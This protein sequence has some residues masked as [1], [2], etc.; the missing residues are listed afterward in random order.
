MDL[1]T[2][3]G[4]VMVSRG[5]RFAEGQTLAIGSW[6]LTFCNVGSSL[7]SGQVL[8]PCVDLQNKTFTGCIVKGQSP[9]N[10]LEG[11]EDL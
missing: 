9:W 11:L 3:A 4:T 6:L 8:F 10:C 2:E 7:C 5:E 1:E